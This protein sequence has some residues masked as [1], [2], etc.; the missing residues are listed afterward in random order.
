ML[1]NKGFLLIEAIFILLITSFLVLLFYQTMEIYHH[2]QK[3]YQSHENQQD[4]DQIRNAY[5]SKIT[6]LYVA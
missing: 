3:Y 4:E 2:A 5:K 6:C 1:K